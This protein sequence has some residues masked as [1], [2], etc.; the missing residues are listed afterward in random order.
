MSTTTQTYTVTG[1]TC[2]HCA[3]AVRA[4]V[5]DIDGVTDV[6]VDVVHGQVTVTSTQAVPVAA[7]RSAV[8]EAGY[9]LT[10]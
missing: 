5:S 8:T 3:R 7:L 1:M 2:D 4:E 6:D 10:A 9:T